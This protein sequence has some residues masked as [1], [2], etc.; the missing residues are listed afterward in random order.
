MFFRAISINQ[1]PFCGPEWVDSTA[2]KHRIFEQAR[3]VSIAPNAC[4]PAGKY[5]IKGTS[6]CTKCA[7]GKYNKETGSIAASACKQCELGKFNDEA[8]M[9]VCEDCATGRYNN[10]TGKIRCIGCASGRYNDEAGSSSES[11]CKQCVTGKYN[12]EAGS[13]SESACKQCTTGKYNDKTG[14]VTELAC[15]DCASGKYS[16]ENGLKDCKNCKSGK[17]GSEIASLNEL[18]CKNCPTGKFSK[19]EGSINCENCTSGKFSDEEGANICAKCEPGKYNAD[20]GSTSSSECE[21][22]LAGTYNTEFGSTSKSACKACSPGRHSISPVE[23]QSSPLSCVACELGK[24]NM[25]EGRVLCQ[26][27]PISFYNN[28]VGSNSFHACKRCPE[29]E[30]GRNMTTKTTGTVS[31]RECEESKCTEDPAQRPISKK[32]VLCPIGFYGDGQ[33]KSCVGIF[34]SQMFT[35]TPAHTQPTDQLISSIIYLIY[36]SPYA[37]QDISKTKKELLIAALAIQ[38]MFFASISLAPLLLQ[39]QLLHNLKNISLVAYF[40]SSTQVGTKV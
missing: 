28:E 8:G 23:G 36:H 35:H 31:I 3:K 17:Y 10:Q 15:K 30:N 9:T 4:C 16:D 34:V 11:A 38:R 1:D 6:T 33:G 40:S 24:Y 13:S 21:K 12:N 14:S 27:C 32:C 25:Y 26:K 29:G 19:D 7:S 2:Y 39:P 18:A 5:W 20:L 22:C 37:P